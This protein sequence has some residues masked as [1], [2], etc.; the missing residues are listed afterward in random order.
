[1][2]RCSQTVWTGPRQY[3]LQG[4]CPHYETPFALS[5]KNFV[6]CIARLCDDRDSLIRDFDDIIFKLNI[7]TSDHLQSTADSPATC[8]QHHSVSLYIETV[9]TLIVSD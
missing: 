3:L 8:M 7:S 1:M 9:Y 4:C 5:A 2:L 6:S